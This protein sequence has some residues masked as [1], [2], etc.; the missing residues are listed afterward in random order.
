MSSA[1]EEPS[2]PMEYKILW[3]YIVLLLA[4]GVMGLVKGKSKIS[5]IASLAFAIPLILCELN[6]I[7]LRYS[8]WILIVLLVFFGWR[9][10]KSKK[11][12]PAGLMV[13]LTV[14]A[15]ALPRIL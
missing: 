7:P 9:L 11:F 12:M 5:L 13:I 1:A 6:I 4:G 15:L 2:R 14:L 3:V 10:L 8:T